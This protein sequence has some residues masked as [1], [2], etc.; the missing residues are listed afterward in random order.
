MIT[1]IAIKIAEKVVEVLR[2]ELLEE[3]NC[4]DEQ[5]KDTEESSANC[6]GDNTDNN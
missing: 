1:A 2:D 5:E 4:E 6:T 3:E